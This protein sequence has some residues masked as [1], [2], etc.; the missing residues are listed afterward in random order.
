M[1]LSAHDSGTPLTRRNF[2]FVIGIS[3]Y[4]SDRHINLSNPVSD[5]EKIVD[6][7]ISRYS[8]ELIA[9]PL[10][11][12]DATRDNII[13]ELNQIIQIVTDQDNL[14]I[15]FAGHGF[16]H[17]TTKQGFW[18][19]FDAES[20]ISDFIPNSTIKDYIE[21][22]DSKHTLIIV[23]SCF[24]GTF[25]TQT[26]E[27]NEEYFYS[28][29]DKLKSR[30]GLTSGGEEPVSDGRP[31]HSSPF[32]NSLVKILVQNTNKYISTNEII[33][34]VVKVTGAN[35]KQQPFGAY[36]ESVNHEG[37]QMVLILKDDFAKEI[38]F[39]SNS[40]PSSDDLLED[41]SHIEF[42]GKQLSTG[43]DVL[44]IKSFIEKE[45]DFLLME[46]FR[47]DDTCSLKHGYKENKIM[48]HYNTTD[49]PVEWEVIR[50]C[51]T[52]SGIEKWLKINPHYLSK[53]TV[54]ISSHPDIEFVEE[55]QC[56]I[57][58]RNYLSSK[59]LEIKSLQCIHCG[60]SISTNDSYLIEIDEIDLPNTIG[61]SH[62]ECLRPVDRIL[63]QSWYR[64]V[65]PNNPLINF[66]FR[67]WIS[68][69]PGGQGQINYIKNRNLDNRTPVIIWNPEHSR[70]HGNYCIEVTLENG[71][72]SF[73]FQNNKIERYTDAEIDRYI[74]LYTKNMEKSND[75]FAIT[76][77]SKTVGNYSQLLKV[78][79]SD[80]DIL[81]ITNYEKKQ[82]SKLFE[83]ESK[84]INN[85]TPLCILTQKQSDK[86][87]A[88]F[89]CI[90][91][92]SDPLTL[93]NYL[94]NWSKGGFVP[95]DFKVDIIKN[96][97][98]F[99]HYMHK[100]FKSGMQPIIDPIFDN[101]LDL[102][103]G[104][105]ITSIDLIK[106]M[107]P[108][109]ERETKFTYSKNPSWLKGDYVKVVFPEVKTDKHAEGILIDDEMINEDGEP[110][111]LFRP[112][113]N[114]IEREDLL[115]TI[116]SKLLVKWK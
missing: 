91:L 61:N 28:K 52:W 45:A 34:Y 93:E 111:V 40:Y 8:F 89:N 106:N 14:I 30:Y 37:G 26:R 12:A 63:G 105:Y 49:E 75:P 116:L 76:S 10:F 51:S 62:L 113:E 67:Q 86:I 98:E 109:Q 47:F 68:S 59:V 38:N 72:K 94:N 20:K 39:S 25:F 101:N 73:L 21:S 46:L 42:Q 55:S 78:K 13:N 97:L 81:I 50:R 33:N 102:V 35:S 19:P 65:S 4:K 3:E 29:I 43:K 57:N 77:K 114:D 96:D 24:S 69:Y 31:G 66:D 23:D 85:Y 100:C 18:I 41:I 44:L 58:H 103:S 16:M 115:F 48:L 84:I 11:N 9:K 82:Y 74:N 36:I 92:I 54:Q 107:A 32:T 27:G 83:K 71:E 88:L 15:L 70:P 112:I 56:A 22:I 17:P 5:C 104:I 7:L 99:E 79:G 95:T 2:L 64:D 1:K 80:E 110:F 90:P 53:R 60:E 87:V 6:L 108:S